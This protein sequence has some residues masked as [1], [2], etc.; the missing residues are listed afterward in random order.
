MKKRWYLLLIAAGLL[1][2]A[3]PLQFPQHLPKPVFALL[4]AGGSVLV[5]G[6]LGSLLCRVIRIRDPVLVQAYKEQHDE[7]N[8]MICE[9]A[10]ARAARVMQG[11]VRDFGAA[12]ARGVELA[13]WITGGGV[14]LWLVLG[15]WWLWWLWWLGWLWWW[16]LWF[17]WWGWGGCFFFQ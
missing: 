14:G 17:L 4:A 1:L 3:V 15:W 6:S 7:R 8:T 16:W 11:A 9:K 2:C 13:L 12:D 5:G 10:A